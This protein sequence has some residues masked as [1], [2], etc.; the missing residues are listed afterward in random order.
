MKNPFF[1]LLLIILVVLDG[2]LLA[3]PNLVGRFGVWFFEYD[4]LNTF[5]KAVGTVS[6]VVGVALI[7]SWLAGRLP[8]PMAIA[9]TALLLVVG[10]LWLIQSLQQYTTGVYKLTGAGFK[11]GAMLLP[12][13][14]VL[15]FAKGLWGLFQRKRK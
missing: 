15:V 7:V 10:L 3:H 8:R 9:A 13:L 11:A 2:W 1:Y 12:G 5:P 14:V 6:A 4:Y